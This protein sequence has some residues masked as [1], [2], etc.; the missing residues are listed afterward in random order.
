MGGVS[1]SAGTS[2][3]GCEAAEMTDESEHFN[4]VWFNTPDGSW[5][6][7]AFVELAARETYLPVS[8]V[9]NRILPHELM[10]IVDAYDRYRAGNKL[11]LLDALFSCQSSNLPLPNWLIE[12]LRDF[13]VQVIQGQPLGR[14]GRGKSPLA[15]ARE[16][17]KRWKRYET[18]RLIRYAQKHPEGD[19]LR[20][21]AIPS[22]TAALINAGKLKG[23][24]TTREDALEVTCLSLRGTF[25]RCSLGTLSRSMHLFEDAEN[26]VSMISHETQVALGLANDLPPELVG[27]FS[28]TPTPEIKFGEFPNHFGDVDPEE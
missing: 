9:K 5:L 28:I 4:K 24:G 18:F 17:V 10:D 22:E 7:K 6:A 25:A 12:G 19:L 26:D 2:G 13:I 14:Q 8:E 21:L 15:E 16:S 23:I 11:A 3:Q 1:R 27:G 20:V